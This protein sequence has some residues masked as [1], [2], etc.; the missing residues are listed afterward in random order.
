[1]R[2]FTVVFL[3]ALSVSINVQSAVY[4]TYAFVK[5][6]N[7]QQFNS[8]ITG[9]TTRLPATKLAIFDMQGKSNE[10]KVKQFIQAEKPSIIIALGSLAANA[11]T[12]IEKQIP[13]VFAM[14]INYQKYSFL[15]Q[16]NVT[17]IS[18]EVPSQKL[19]NQFKMLIP[20]IKSIGV[21]FHPLASAEIVNDA[22]LVASKMDIKLVDIE[23]TDPN[24]ITAK[25]HEKINSYD[26]LWMLA[27]TKLYNNKTNAIH[28]LMSFSN[29][30]NKPL[31][32]F[33][34]SFLQAGA[35]FSITIDYQSLGIQTA[36]VVNKIVEDKLSPTQIKIAPPI[37]IYRILN[38]ENAKLLEKEFSGSK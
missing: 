9:F 28:D 7:L 21:P 37:G 6:E 18:M 16:D 11:V 32:A 29:K 19:F 4:E 12:K 17:G 2:Q 22:L 10:K 8:V 30:Y 25:L 36:F 34:E 38:E 24:N 5:S 15:K 3:L 13:I 1:M 27:D 14:V 20:S 33:S 23:V 26:S 35:F 31:L